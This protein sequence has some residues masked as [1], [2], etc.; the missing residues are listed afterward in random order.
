M[1]S[2]IRQFPS[3]Q[4]YKG[5]LIDAPSITNRVL[6]QP[7]ANLKADLNLKSTM[8]FDLKY[9]MESYSETS[10]NNL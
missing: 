3:E 7:L 2:A 10:K 5:K 4:F 1:E 6:D 9:S 8:F